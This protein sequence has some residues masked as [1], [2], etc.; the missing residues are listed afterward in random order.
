[1]IT[2]ISIGD[3]GIKE[4]LEFGQKHGRYFERDDLDERIP[5]LGDL[6]L[7]DDTIKSMGDK[8]GKY[9]HITHSFKEDEIPQHIMSEIVQDFNHYFTSA[10]GGDETISYAEA[11]NPRIKSY[12]DKNGKIV[13]RKPHIHMV[14]PRVNLKNGKSFDV[15]IKDYIKF[16][17]AWQEH[18]N[19]KYGL[20]SPKDN[21]R[22]KINDNSEFISRYTGDGFKGKNKD[23]KVNLLN[24][25]L[26]KNI[27]SMDEL[28]SYLTHNGYAYKIRNSNKSLDEQ[29]I[30]I[31]HKDGN[32]NLRDHV[33]RDEFLRLSSAEKL[34]KIHNDSNFKRTALILPGAERPTNEDHK[35]LMDEWLNYKSFENR[36]TVNFSQKQREKFKD[37][38]ENEKKLIIE[39]FKTKLANENKIGEDIG[40]KFTTNE[41]QRV[42]DSAIES[43]RS[44]SASLED[45]LSRRSGNERV[46]DSQR[47]GWRDVVKGRFG[48][49]AGQ[50]WGGQ[51]GYDGYIDS[52]A[53][54]VINPTSS[55]VIGGLDYKYN[56]N[57]V[58]NSYQKD[59]ITKFNKELK[60]DILLEL[61]EKSHG[62]NPELYR[63]TI[64]RD[65]SDRIG[66][67][68]RNLT[69][70][71]FIK[72]H[73]N[74]PIP[75]SLDILQKAY[76]MQQHINVKE[77]YK[78]ATGNYLFEEYQQWFDSYKNEREQLIFNNKSNVNSIKQ[79]LLDKY[80]RQIETIKLDKSII[81]K[82]K[83]LRISAL[84][85]EQKTELNELKKTLF[86]INSDTRKT[87]NIE[88][89]N[90]Y[91]VFLQRK[92]QEDDERAIQ[93]LRRLRIDYQKITTQLTFNYVERYQEYKLP[94]THEID[95]NG[96]IHYKLN[97]KTIIKDH[98]SK[99]EVT[100]VQDKSLELSFN[101]AR[102]KF[103]NV[104][105]LGGD[106]SFKKKCIEYAL[107]KGL[108]ITFT[109][110]F[111]KSY[112]HS[113]LKQYSDKSDQLSQ[114]SQ[115]LLE[116]RPTKL[117]IDNIHSQNLL[118]N[119]RLNQINTVR[120]K[121]LETNEYHEICNSQLNFMLKNFAAGELV[122]IYLDK[123]TNE[124][125]IKHANEHKV[126]QEIAK[127][128]IKT[129]QAKFINEIMAKYNVQNLGSETIG[130]VVRRT[131]DPKT[132][133]VRSILIK[134][135]SG[136]LKITNQ[137][138]INQLN[139][140]E[141]GS[142]ISIVS[143]KGQDEIRYK[144]EK[145]TVV[146]KQYSIAEVFNEYK[147]NQQ[148]I[149]AEIIKQKPLITASGQ[150]ITKISFKNIETGKI[151][152]I[153][154]KKPLDCINGEVYCFDK[155]GWNSYKVSQTPDGIKQIF[156]QLKTTSEHT[157]GTVKNYGEANIRGKNVWFIELQTT[158]GVVKK[159][160]DNLKKLIDKEGIEIG[161]TISIKQESK[162]VE[163]LTKQT[164]M[165]AKN[166]SQN[167][168]QQID[169]IIHA[170]NNDIK[171]EVN[172]KK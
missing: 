141:L 64:A 120:L 96:V 134:H 23:F 41:Y 154:S 159:Y 68:T 49:S 46:S 131:R 67:G 70:F 101:L 110:D 44:N 92:A 152:A 157:C 29:Y 104:I 31:E 93:E 79:K 69:N 58:K 156:E 107:S 73:I 33:F 91:R 72:Q 20:E 158:N 168:E 86:Q 12:I 114:N 52:G 57:I 125:L 162:L 40:A 150:S 24:D 48:R 113:L 103:G 149:L 10:F 89:Q 172:D 83:K 87:Y 8:K 15:F 160:G 22:Y 26:L 129:N 59:L 143:I 169:N 170:K 21:P 116:K 9:F 6:D 85:F 132:S 2:E 105:N 54:R 119:G 161:E 117:I 71:D 32:I 99:V 124:V 60:S 118:I 151:E 121:D 19:A 47:V 65:G 139:S 34:K 100:R 164:I 111:S 56:Q 88:M 11:H 37:L 81:A 115:I 16:N 62:V 112:Q 39:Q 78:N 80:K 27:L 51:D 3:D 4:Y 136:F 153:F 171:S 13:E 82:D 128:I 63:I 133:R 77:T 127:D 123:H 90:A 28:K 165:E 25:I 30:N 130:K 140:A 144:A 45:T 108:P 137:N 106:D 1:M 146:A 102:N 74:L 76:N 38:P 50:S 36:Y 55:S 163:Y 61:L 148:S 126:R 14:I 5:L 135:D 42:I 109:D 145:Q 75:L 43:T 84:K 97:H 53:I 155:L 17:D 147:T 122:N 7:V 166:L 66:V 35:N 98:G 167:L 95:K 94:I 18:I 142:T 138:V